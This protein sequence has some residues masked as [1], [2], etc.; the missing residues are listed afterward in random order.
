MFSAEILADVVRGV[1]ERLSPAETKR[2][3]E[4]WVLTEVRLEPDSDTH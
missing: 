3:S 4:V 2:P 1:D